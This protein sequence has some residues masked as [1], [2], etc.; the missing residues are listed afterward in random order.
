VT[1]AAGRRYRMRY[2]ITAEGLR[3]LPRLNSQRGFVARA[4]AAQPADIRGVI[5]AAEEA[6]MRCDG[7][8]YRVI[9]WHLN[10]LRH[11]GF[12]EAEA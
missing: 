3:A 1:R 5:A 4:V 10:D 12:I 2:R 11:R 9:A 7:D 6:G 8:L